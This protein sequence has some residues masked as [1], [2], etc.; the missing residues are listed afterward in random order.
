MARYLIMP[1]R[2]APFAVLILIPRAIIRQKKKSG[3]LCAHRPPNHLYRVSR[4]NRKVRFL[5][6]M[7][8]RFAVSE[9]A[10]ACSPPI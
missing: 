8:L 5:G 10:K 7:V 1:A 2:R 4:L 3:I 9:S 6:R